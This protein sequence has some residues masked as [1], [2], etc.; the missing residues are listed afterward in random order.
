MQVGEALQNRL[1]W[2]VTEEVTEVRPLR[3]R[4]MDPHRN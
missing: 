1:A 2:I 3:S 4:A